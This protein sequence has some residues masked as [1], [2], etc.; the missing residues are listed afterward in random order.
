MVGATE[1]LGACVVE[2][3][4]P[5]TVVLVVSGYCFRQPANKVAVIK[6]LN[7]IIPALFMEFPPF[8][9]EFDAIISRNRRIT[10]VICAVR[11]VSDR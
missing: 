9:L 4:V 3:V 5:G 10:L 8:L 2:W 6:M 11:M 1:G 7:A